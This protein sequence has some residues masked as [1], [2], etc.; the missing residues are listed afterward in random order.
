VSLA[1][2]SVSTRILVRS[3]GGWAEVRRGERV[4]GDQRIL[5]STDFVLTVLR[6]AGHDLERKTMLRTQGHTLESVAL[7]ISRLYRITPSELLTKGRFPIRVEARSLLCH[8]AVHDLGMSLTE[9]ARRL[10]MTPSAIG[11]AA[12]E[13]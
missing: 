10:G 3:L 5:G 1:G 6:R 13:R 7:R 12:N 9:L 4:K 8:V 2:K 11:Y